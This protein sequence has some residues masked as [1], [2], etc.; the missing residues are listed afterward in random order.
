MRTGKNLAKL[1]RELKVDPSDFEQFLLRSGIKS[2]EL[3]VFLDD[4]RVPDREAWQTE[5]DRLGFAALLDAGFD[6]RKDAGFVT[7][8]CD[9]YATGF[10]FALSPAANIISH[11]P[12]LAA[13]VGARDKCATF[14]WGGDIA[15]EHA[16]L[17][18][19]AALA[20]I[21]DG[22]WF[23]PANGSVYNGDEAVE[24]ARRSHRLINSLGR[25]FGMREP[26]RTMILILAVAAILFM[27]LAR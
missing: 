17:S 9:G 27:L 12:H 4:S 11:Y 2:I 6:V 1:A 16:V 14:I 15:E 3:H 5:I 20:K 23:S 13:R 7:V 24:Q 10:Y 18:A 22:I 21:A 19:A 25:R 8:T 26:W